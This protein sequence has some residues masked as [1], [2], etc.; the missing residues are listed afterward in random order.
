MFWGLGHQRP[1][2]DGYIYIHY[3]APPYTA[4]ISTIY[5]LPFGN[6]SLGSVSV[7]HTWE[8]ESTMQNLRRVGENSDSILSRL[9]TKVHEI[10]R[11]CRKFLVLSNALFQLSVSRFVQ[12]IFAI[13]SRSRR[14]TEQ[15]QAFC[16]PQFLWEERL[17]LFYGSLLGRLTHGKVWLSSVCWS[18]SAKPGNEPECR[19]Y[20]GWVKCRSS[21]KSFVDQSSWHFGMM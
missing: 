9:W 14:K 8:L 13:K 21:L 4:R 10:F 18:P 6:V 5:F 12:K 2:F 20:G 17:R 3:V 1:N 19:I 7:Y 11:R 16:G 15:M